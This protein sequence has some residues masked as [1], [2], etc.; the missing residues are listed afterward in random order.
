MPPKGQKEPLVYCCCKKCIVEGQ[1]K[2][3]SQLILRTQKSARQHCNL[4]TAPLGIAFQFQDSSFTGYADLQR[5]LRLAEPEQQQQQPAEPAVALAVVEQ[6]DQHAHN[7]SDVEEELQEGWPQL[8]DAQPSEDSA[9]ESDSASDSASVSSVDPEEEQRVAEVQAVADVLEHHV[10]ELQAAQ[11]AAQRNPADTRLAELLTRVTPGNDG[12]KR[13]PA[14]ELAA[15]QFKDNGCEQDRLVQACQGLFAL[16]T[17]H[18]L[19]DAALTG[20]LDWAHNL[21]PMEAAFKDNLPSNVRTARGALRTLAGIKAE[22]LV[23]D[24]C[25]CGGLYR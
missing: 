24:M 5:Q 25:P 8:P 3:P 6:P 13:V 23:Y 18:A 4:Y 14:A 15:Y 16:K 19:P 10:A 21:I 1:N 22:Y 7:G 17:K 20:I 11:Q 12:G 9:G 2:P